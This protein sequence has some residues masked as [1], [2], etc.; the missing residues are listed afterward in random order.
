MIPAIHVP[1]FFTPVCYFLY[2]TIS[3]YLPLTPSTCQPQP[4][5][6][7][8]HLIT[9]A[10]LN[11]IIQKKSVYGWREWYSG[12]APFPPTNLNPTIT[13]PSRIKLPTTE[14]FPSRWPQE[15]QEAYLVMTILAATRHPSVCQV[16]LVR[17]TTLNPL[18]LLAN[19][20]LFF[21]RR[22]TT[23][24]TAFQRHLIHCLIILSQHQLQRPP[25]NLPTSS[26]TSQPTRCRWVPSPLASYST[27]NAPNRC[28]PPSL[29][30]LNYLAPI[31]IH[32][33]FNP[34]YT[35]LQFL[36]SLCLSKLKNIPFSLL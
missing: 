24:T 17:K 20:N 30:P 29:F 7:F 36:S 4:T 22:C 11:S 26:T 25:T 32:I 13:S 12:I 23:T 3:T 5:P 15:V 19:L 34:P 27:S 35:T 6:I 31:L 14:V 2:H 8:Q 33:F 9:S 18:N 28:Q 21:Q 10:T 16:N 1:I